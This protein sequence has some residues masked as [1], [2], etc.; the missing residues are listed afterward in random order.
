MEAL[1]SRL[2]LVAEAAELLMGESSLVKD[3]H[4]RIFLRYC[5]NQ[6]LNPGALT[7]GNICNFASEH[8]DGGFAPAYTMAIVSTIVS[9]YELALG[10]ALRS[11]ALGQLSKQLKKR[12]SRF[13]NMDITEFPMDYESC[14]LQPLVL[15]LFPLSA[16]EPVSFRVTALKMAHLRLLMLGMVRFY[17]PLRSSDVAH[18]WRPSCK[19]FSEAGVKKFS[20]R[21]L[22]SK[23]SHNISAPITVSC[24]CSQEEANPSHRFCLVCVAQEYLDRTATQAI[25]QHQYV[26][27]GNCC[28]G[29]PCDD[30]S[31]LFLALSRSKGKYYAVS[32]DRIG[33]LTKEIFKLL[34]WSDVYKP[35]WLRAL[36]ARRLERSQGALVARAAGFWVEGSTAFRSAYNPVVISLIPPEFITA[37][38]ALMTEVD[39]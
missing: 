28:K 16:T 22:F 9:T 7:E 36:T 2:G 21:T 3:S 11:V 4:W 29:F 33:S 35:H 13:P 25:C 32:P 12:K 10:E 6:N 19:F 30:G 18:M 34:N 15:A 20:F 39:C 14:F 31:F 23:S 17:A 37:Q 1:S 5:T 26:G 24:V 38:N 8:H 27:L